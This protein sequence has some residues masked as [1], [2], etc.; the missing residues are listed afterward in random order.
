MNPF[1]IKIEIEISHMECVSNMMM[2]TLRNKVSIYDPYDRG[3]DV[4][5]R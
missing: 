5:Q 1:C 4:R 3:L 2:V